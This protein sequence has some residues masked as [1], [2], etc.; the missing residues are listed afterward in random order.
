[1]I[2]DGTPNKS[3]HASRASGLLIENLR[4]SQLR[5]A[6]PT[7]PFG[8]VYV[9]F[10]KPQLFGLVFGLLFL[11]TCSASADS[12][13][14]DESWSPVVN[15]LQS[16][17]TLTQAEPL[18]GTRWIVPSLELRNV[19]D[20]VNQMEVNCD[21][22][23]LTVE[24][25]NEN[26][27]PVRSGWIMPRSGPAPQLDT[28]ILPW[29]SAITLSLENRNWGIPRS[30]PAMISTDS[31]AW[32]LDDSEKGKVFLRA[33]LTDEPLKPSSWIRWYGKIQTPLLKVDWK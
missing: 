24:L 7:Q 26:G 18:N 2:L 10:M 8:R 3:L 5:A 13:L 30:A 22:H 16:R 33:T 14:K 17:L 19:R 12:S 27:D 29:H 28:I 15:G 11:F 4:V 21:R 6:A 9:S 20:L 32:V 23:H 1:M 31:G 25:V